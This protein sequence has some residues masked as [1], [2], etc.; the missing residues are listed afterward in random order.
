M[1]IHKIF[2]KAHT[3]S[4]FL[5]N[6]DFNQENDWLANNNGIKKLDLLKKSKFY[7]P[8]FV[9]LS[10]DLPNTIDMRLNVIFLR[11]FKLNESTRD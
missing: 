8:N 1:L 11:F 3:G 4:N 10:N 5:K 6:Y 2:E 7:C 9:L